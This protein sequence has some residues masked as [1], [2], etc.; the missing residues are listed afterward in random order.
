MQLD[1]YLKYVFYYFEA[2]KMKLWYLSCDTVL[3]NNSTEAPIFE[4][5]FKFGRKN[6]KMFYNKRELDWRNDI[7]TQSKMQVQHC[8][9]IYKGEG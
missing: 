7:R 9:A 2:N 3:N 4:R 8:L 1:T 6:T 5:I